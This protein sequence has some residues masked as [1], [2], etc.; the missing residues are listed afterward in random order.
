MGSIQ[1]SIVCPQ[2]GHMEAYCTYYYKTGEEY[3]FCPLCGYQKE[4]TIKCNEKGGW[5]M[6]TDVYEIDG[7]TVGYSRLVDPAGADLLSDFT[8]FTPECAAEELKAIEKK[9]GVYIIKLDTQEEYGF[10]H[11]SFWNSREIKYE[12]GKAF[13]H[14]TYP[15]YT[16]TEKAGAGIC[17]VA[18]KG[19]AAHLYDIRDV[20][21]AEMLY[22][23]QQP[24]YREASYI[25]KVEDGQIKFLA[26]ASLWSEEKEP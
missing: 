2:C 26:G 9:R 8:P 18:G 13:L 10:R 21:L 4:N 6:Q 7:K 3:I 23:V 24:E 15:I 25:T 17:C 20:D 19:F 1:E 5:L 14:H 11:L 12:N 22:V 16:V